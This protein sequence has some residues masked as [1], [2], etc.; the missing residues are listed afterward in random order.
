MGDSTPDMLLEE[1]KP[2]WDH[3]IASERAARTAAQAR[4]QPFGC[5]VQRRLS[6]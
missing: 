6:L 3:A 5:M 2:Y 1:A 4:Y